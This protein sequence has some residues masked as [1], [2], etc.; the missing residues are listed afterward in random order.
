MVRSGICGLSPCKRLKSRQ[1]GIY[2]VY[3]LRDFLPNPDVPKMVQKREPFLNG[4]LREVGFGK[5]FAYK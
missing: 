5:S 1:M 4:T 3:K 2:I